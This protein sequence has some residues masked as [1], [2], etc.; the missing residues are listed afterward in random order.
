MSRKAF[1]VT[2]I[3]LLTSVTHADAPQP[4][5]YPVYISKLPNPNDYNLFANSGWDGN[6]YV[7][8]NTCWIKKLPFIQPGTYTRAYLGAKLGRMKLLPN[9]KN[10]WDKKPVPGAIYMAIASTTAWNSDHGF[11]LTTTEDIRWKGMKKARLKV[12]ENRSGLDRDS[13]ECD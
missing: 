2:L 3:V 5:D 1:V 11:L 8:Y 4:S 13:V 7:G 9:T 10:V 6:W 12:Q